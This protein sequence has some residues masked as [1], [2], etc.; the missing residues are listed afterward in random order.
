MCSLDCKL[1]S[2]GSF[3]ISPTDSIHFC[4]D[5]KRGFHA[6]LGSM[7]LKLG[8]VGSLVLYQDGKRCYGVVYSLSGRLFSAACMQ[9]GKSL[10]GFYLRL[11][12][13]EVLEQVSYV[14]GNFTFWRKTILGIFGYIFSLYFTSQSLFA[15]AVCKNTLDS[16]M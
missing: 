2:Q 16:D 14:C 7:L 9:L 10:F 11:F 3:K 1:G 6:V 15:N 13:V 5:E 12:S 8:I 4:W